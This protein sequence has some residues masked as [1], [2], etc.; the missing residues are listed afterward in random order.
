M[1]V[2][3]LL[4]P[5]PQP[6]H[7]PTS[8]LLDGRVGWRAARWEHLD[9]LP[10]QHALTLVSMSKRTLTEASGSF[11]GLTAPANVALGPDDSIYLL[12][13][14][15]AQLKRFDP[16]TCQFVPVPC[17]GG[18]GGGP[19]QLR[20]PHGIGICSRN[21]F[22]CDTN[23]HRV[24][25]FALHG[26]VLCGHWQPPQSAYQGTHPKL[27]NKWEPFD[28]AFDQHGNVYVTDGANGCIHCFTP[29]GRW[30]K[31]FAG[32]GSVTWIAID[33]RDRIYAVVAGLAPEIRTIDAT[34]AQAS[35]SPADETPDL[36]RVP[37]E[38]E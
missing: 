7:D 2:S 10:P 13:T 25:V 36:P 33:C 12:D 23:N 17:F 22:V 3:T 27:V 19:R 5:I 14:Q 18:V 11:G 1:A 9:Q 30:E 4:P 37:F 29:N 35:L 20:N 6:P 21:L 38:I 8:W 24:S 34:G 16:C 15:H 31:V 32:F 28:L 26:F